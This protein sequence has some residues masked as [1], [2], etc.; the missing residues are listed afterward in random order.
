MGEQSEI[1]GKWSFTPKKVKE[2]REFKAEA[3][4]DERKRGWLLTSTEVKDQRTS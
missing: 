4:N 1:R 2:G 3:E